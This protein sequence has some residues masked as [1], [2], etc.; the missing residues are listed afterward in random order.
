MLHTALPTIPISD[1]RT[2]QPEIMNSLAQSPIMF[3]RQGYGAGVLVHPRLWN[4]LIA[5]HQKAQAAGLVD[6]NDA[7]RIDWKTGEQEYFSKKPAHVDGETVLYGK[8]I[9]VGGVEPRVELK[10]LVGQILSCATTVEIAIQLANRLY[11]QVGVFGHATWD[12]EKLEIQEFRISRVLAYE[13]KPLTHAFKL[14][15]EVTQKEFD[16][17]EDV[18]QYITNLRHGEDAD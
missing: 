14:L 16:V 4:Y 11:Q 18:D 5:I 9:R 8:V 13:K 12:Q 1:L 15:R 3:T 6:V 17:I 10:P 2:K 7:Q